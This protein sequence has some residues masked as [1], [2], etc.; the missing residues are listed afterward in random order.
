MRI[1]ECRIG[2]GGIRRRIKR[3]SGASAGNHAKADLD[4]WCVMQQ[5]LCVEIEA[6][7][8]MMH[9]IILELTKVELDN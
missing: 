3:V 1:S 7:T 5:R 4:Q 6:D 8:S 2:F 9:C